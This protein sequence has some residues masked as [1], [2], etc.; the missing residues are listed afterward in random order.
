MLS[1]ATALPRV[2]LLSTLNFL[3]PFSLFH[4]FVLVR[5]APFPSSGL[6]SFSFLNHGLRF[7]GTF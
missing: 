1:P 4:S 3:L 5:L 7:P 2:R 6:F